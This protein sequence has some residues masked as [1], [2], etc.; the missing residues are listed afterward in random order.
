MTG[1]T[2]L[3]KEASRMKR[4]WTRLGRSAYAKIKGGCTIAA[5]PD[6]HS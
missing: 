1:M 3:S 4:E 5:V 6:H 2:P